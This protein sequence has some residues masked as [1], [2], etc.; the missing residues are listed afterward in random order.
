MEQSKPSQTSELSDDD[1]NDSEFFSSKLTTDVD[2]FAK[3]SN[4]PSE[5]VD[6]L[7]NSESVSGTANATIDLIDSVLE[8]GVSGPSPEE[9]L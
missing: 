7:A 5:S 8:C 4:D 9:N 1:E 6:V 3:A 2:V